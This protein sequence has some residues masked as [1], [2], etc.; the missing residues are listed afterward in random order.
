MAMASIQQRRRGLYLRLPVCANILDLETAVHRY[1]VSRLI[2]GLQFFDK[3]SVL[4]I[5]WSVF[6]AEM[7][8]L[9]DSSQAPSVSFLVGPLCT[10][11]T[12]PSG[13]TSRGGPD[14]LISICI[15]LYE[16]LYDVSDARLARNKFP[17]EA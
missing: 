14:S 9:T 4:H 1:N 17:N 13:L 6:R 3:L 2:P 16:S 11:F 15:I 8:I 5:D 10:R 12:G 7:G